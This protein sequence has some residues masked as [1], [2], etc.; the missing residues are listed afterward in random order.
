MYQPE[1]PENF[2]KSISMRKYIQILPNF[3]Q[4]IANDL[5]LLSYSSAQAAM[6]HLKLGNPELKNLWEYNKEDK[7]IKL[8]LES[9]NSGRKIDLNLF[10]EIKKPN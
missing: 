9:T 10:F 3:G 1:N 4:T 2:Q 7:Y 5:E 8:R 6:P